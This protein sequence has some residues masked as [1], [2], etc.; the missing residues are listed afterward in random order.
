MNIAIVGVGLI[1]GSIALRLRE[2]EQ[3]D[4]IIGVDKSEAN[5]KKA[6]QLKLVDEFV[7]L[8]EAIDQ[9]KVVI[10]ATPVSETVQRAPYILDRVTDQVLIDMGSTQINILEQIADHPKRGRYGAAHPMAGTE[11]SGPEAALP[12]LFKDKNMVYVEAF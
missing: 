11:Y 9:C 6:L 5:R 10:L 7:T 8:E 2:T 12:D 3:Y 1:G 4:K